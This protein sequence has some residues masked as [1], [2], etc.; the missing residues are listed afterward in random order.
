M[1]KIII[2]D[3]KV[4]TIIGIF[5]WER[6]IKQCLYIDLDMEV[7]ISQAAA[8]DDLQY[9]VDYAEVCERVT[10][11]ANDKKFKLLEAFIENIAA[12]NVRFFLPHDYH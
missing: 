4:E 9:I 8:T 1:D 6:K 11:L 2:S 12:L 5:P 7:D 3:L 10:T